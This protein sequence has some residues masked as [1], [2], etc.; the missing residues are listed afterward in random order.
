MQLYESYKPSGIQWVEKIPSHWGAERAKWLFNRMERPVRPEDDVVTAFRDGQVTLRTNRR[1]EGFTNAIQEHGYQGIRKGDLVIHAMDA[2]AG[3]IGVSDSDGKSTPVYA[4]C[5]PRGEYPVNSFYYAY[6]LRYMA[7]SGYIESLSKGIR[8]RSTDFRFAEFRELPL[9]IP[10]KDEQDRIVAFLDQKTAEIEA[11]IEKKKRLI[12]LLEEQKQGLIDQ[13]VTVGRA[14]CVPLQ[15][16]ETPGLSEVAATWSMRKLKHVC[17]YQEGPGIMASDFKESGVPLIRIAGVKGGQVSLEGCN[18]LSEQK[19]KRR[20]EHF[21][22]NRGDLLISGS[23]SSGIVSE[24]TEIADGAVAY[25]G[26]F[27]IILDQGLLEK[28]F[29]KLYFVSSAFNEQMDLF[30]TGVGLQH[31]GPSHLSRAWIALPGLNEQKEI[32]EFVGERAACIDELI[33]ATK[34]VIESLRVG[35]TSLVASVVLGQFKV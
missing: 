31:F 19:V 35:K 28:D 26:L 23:A 20:W 9:P 10:N 34:K 4:A 5:V 7:H 1:T 13:A 8:E 16:T 21:R 25:T 29:A 11:T 18:F 14:F 32:V 6:L 2:F 24:V 33:T 15:K 17:Q 30:K 22:L 12:E 27:R 3:A